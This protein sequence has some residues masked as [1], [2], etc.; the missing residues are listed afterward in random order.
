MT[1]LQDDIH[2]LVTPQ[3]AVVEHFSRHLDSAS[4]TWSIAVPARS[5]VSTFVDQSIVDHQQLNAIVLREPL[6]TV[7]FLL[8]NCTYLRKVEPCERARIYINF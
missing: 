4:V 5:H 3:V 7:S 6:I 1:S 8:I 2:D